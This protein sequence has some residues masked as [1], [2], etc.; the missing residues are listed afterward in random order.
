[1]A[2]PIP[3]PPPSQIKMEQLTALSNTKLLPLPLQPATKFNLPS[4]STLNAAN[5]TQPPSSNNYRP[6]LHPPTFPN[7]T[8]PPMSSSVL[9]PLSSSFSN[10]PPSSSSNQLPSISQLYADPPVALNLSDH[11]TYFNIARNLF[12]NGE[13]LPQHLNSQ[14]FPGNY[15]RSSK[16]NHNIQDRRA[17]L[18][19]FSFFFEEIDPHDDSILNKMQ[20]HS[21]HYQSV[22]ETFPAPSFKSFT[23]LSYTISSIE[24]CHRINV[25]LFGQ[26]N[27][28]LYLDSQQ[29]M[30]HAQFAW[31][32]L[33]HLSSI[34][35]RPTFNLETCNVHLAATIVYLG[36]ATASSSRRKLEPF[37]RSLV[38]Q[39]RASL[40]MSENTH[41]VMDN[42][43][44][45][46]SLS[47]LSWYNYNFVYAEEDPFYPVITEINST[48]VRYAMLGGVVHS[49]SDAQI[50]LGNATVNSDAYTFFQASDPNAPHD[51]WLTWVTHESL[52]RVNHF[53]NHCELIRKY[54]GQHPFEDSLVN[55]DLI[56]IC[57]PALWRASS[58]EMFFHIVG[59]N[60]SIASIPYLLLLKSMLRIPPVGD[61]KSR[62]DSVNYSHGK[63]GWT[64]SHLYVV[65]FGLVTIGWVIEGCFSYQQMVATRD[66]LKPSRP[67]GDDSE[68]GYVSDGSSTSSMSG[69]APIP[70]PAAA[71][72]AAVVVDSRIQS[73]LSY[74]MEMWVELSTT[75][76]RQF[77]D[78][79]IQS[80]VLNS[81]SSD[82]YEYN[83]IWSD[84]DRALPWDGITSLCISFQTCYFSMYTEGKFE[85]KLINS[86]AENLDA[87]SRMVI[88]DWTPQQVE[89]FIMFGTTTPTQS[90]I[91]D[92]ARWIE[93][94]IS[95][96][97]ITIAAYF[98]LNLVNSSTPT[99][100]GGG[101]VA[102]ARFILPPA[103]LILW[104]YD[105]Y[106]RISTSA[107]TGVPL[108][109]IEYT[110]Y[111]RSCI[112]Q[113]TKIDPHPI[114]S[115][116]IGLI[117]KTFMTTCGYE[118]PKRTE[119]R[120][121]SVRS[122]SDR[123]G[124]NSLLND[125]VPAQNTSEPCNIF[126]FLALLCYLE[127]SKLRL[128]P[129][130][131]HT[132]IVKKVRAVL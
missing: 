83:P 63:N 118:V 93:K 32:K 38:H 56:M 65:I 84:S 80:P 28:K 9:K 2:P 85:A 41:A 131:P 59:P 69:P 73:R 105:Y 90:G 15:L 5:S 26:H 88:T 113:P 95:F 19:S 100:L 86:V 110:E 114:K 51:Q 52:I 31:V 119:E 7:A 94:D 82:A 116:H 91:D 121:S 21:H 132:D 111:Y 27:T 122:T 66:N 70:D 35:H 16:I 47:L 79:K 74:A 96:N 3:Q 78:F 104:A 30:D 67:D 22:A 106:K 108:A 54:L 68:R 25:A 60:R 58:A 112:H 109:P 81:T 72:A 42:L 87:L 123:I 89:S 11:A 124:I 130:V 98:L 34:I 29:L 57:S 97:K 77:I 53:M 33:E 49:K 39:S 101:D 115:Q 50:H 13:R 24:R 8:A 75:C 61:D 102:S 4:P 45:Y 120:I 23:R 6:Y 20:H 48:L 17:M 76:T 103:C 99:C 127:E 40:D 1:M 36:M 43:G 10:P 62:I 55:S 129:G 46:Q 126:S 125:V 44:Y 92:L 18:D 64:L 71:A 128:D 12:Q 117:H 14:P 107:T 37:Y